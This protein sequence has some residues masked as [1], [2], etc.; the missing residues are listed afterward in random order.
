MKKHTILILTFL[1]VSFSNLAFANDSTQLYSNSHALI[2]GASNYQHLKKLP[3]VKEDVLKVQIALEAKGFQVDTVLNPDNKA[4]EKAFDDFIS[5][6]GGDK[7]ARLLFYFAGHG[8]TLMPQYGGEKMGYIL[9]VNTPSPVNDRSNFMKLA[10]S[11]KRIEEYALRIDSKHALF[12]FDACFSGTIFNVTRDIV[13]EDISYKTIKPVRQFISSGTKD[14]IVPDKSIFCEL[15][16]EG[17]EGK[18]DLIKDGY[19]TVSELGNYLESNVTKYSGNTQHP[20]YGKINNPNL[21]KGDFVFRASKTST[22]PNDLNYDPDAWLATVKNKRAIIETDTTAK[23]EK[24][25]TD[26]WTILVYLDGD[27]NLEE[28]AIDDLN[29]M[30][31]VQLPDNI[32]VIV[33]IDR[34]DGHD[35]SN[36]NWTGTRIYEV[37]HDTNSKQIGSKLIKDQGELNMGNPQTLTD[38]INFGTRN[39]P[40]KKYMLVMWNHGGGWR[41]IEEANPENLRGISWDETSNNDYLEMR[42]VESALKSANQKMN[43]LGFDACLMGMFE[44]AYQVKDAVKELAIF[45]QEVE[46]GDGWDYNAFLNKLKTNPSADAKELAKYVTSSYQAFYSYQNTTISAVDLTKAPGLKSAIDNFA[47]TFMKSPEWQVLKSAANASPEFEHR[48][49]YVDLYQLMNYVSTKSNSFDTRLAAKEVLIA[50]NHFVIEN[51]TTGSFNNKAKGLNIYFKRGNDSEWRYYNGTY[52]DFAGESSWPDLLIEKNKHKNGNDE[53]NGDSEDNKKNITTLDK[54]KGSELVVEYVDGSKNIKT[55]NVVANIYMRIKCISG[56]LVCPVSFTVNG[57]TKGGVNTLGQNIWS[58]WHV[59]ESCT[60][61]F[62]YEVGYRIEGNCIIQAQVMYYA[63]NKSDKSNVADLVLSKEEIG[64]FLQND[65]SFRHDYNN[66]QKINESESRGFIKIQDVGE[67]AEN[68]EV[69]L[70][71]TLTYTPSNLDEYKKREKEKIKEFNEK[72]KKTLM[73]LRKKDKKN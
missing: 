16:I 61:S 47:K 58:K 60:G 41:D 73:H 68:N 10:M 40:A 12:V 70:N 51:K 54:S 15:F 62:G 25:T 9:P 37:K 57:N 50:L 35:Y 65:Y 43:V 4:L 6:Y 39:Y 17:I 21:D 18:A 28:F 27:N 2:I 64:N 36:G 59:V 20:Q 14:E 29:E 19:V 24:Y 34:V 55:A 63:D 22:A 38:F 69:V 5:K 45:S 7:N 8:H 44:V 46:P 30:E 13:P 26:D 11:M 49:N 52:C 72:Q 3:G 32:N 1:V 71:D 48:F 66:Y 31:S 23:N 33:Q 53:N 67:N 42:E 56:A